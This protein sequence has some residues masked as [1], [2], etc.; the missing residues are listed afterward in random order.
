MKRFSREKPE[1][2]LAVGDVGILPTDTLYG[3][4][5]SAFSKKAVA[6]IFNVKKRNAK[7]PLI[8]LVSSLSDLSRF[9]IALD[10]HTRSAL[11]RFWPGKVSVILPCPHR[12]FSYLHRGT[13]TLAFRLPK[14]K[15][16]RALLAKTGPLA[17]PSANPEG[18]PPA[19]TV[20]EARAYFGNE[21]DFYISA[22][23]RVVSKPSTL[24]RF[25]HGAF[26]VV[27]QGAGRIKSLTGRPSSCIVKV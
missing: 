27:R 21:A 16:L 24:V 2:M 20:K 9:G 6:R 7:K 23:R 10:Q 19:E 4:V 22:G 18:L 11:S 15:S 3:I 14:K 12:R 25:E 8:I 26:I 1:N 17:A 13:K 5:G